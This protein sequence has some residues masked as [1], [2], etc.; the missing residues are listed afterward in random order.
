MFRC[1]SLATPECHP[2]SAGPR[3]AI[4]KARQNGIRQKRGSRA[5]TT[6]ILHRQDTVRQGQAPW[7]LP[8]LNIINILPLTI[9]A[10]LPQQTTNLHLVPCLCLGRCRRLEHVQLIEGSDAVAAAK[11]VHVVLVG[12]RG[13]CPA[14]RRN[15]PVRLRLKPLK[16]LCLRCSYTVG[17]LAMPWQAAM[18]SQSGTT[19]KI[20]NPIPLRT[21]GTTPHPTQPTA[22]IP[23]SRTCKSLK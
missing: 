23:Q 15:F 5:L 13:V 11:D 14:F 6:R 21:P 8:K 19:H 17:A 7:A 1:G 2:L 18:A 20:A 10:P 16:G 12:N 4:I 22:G 9:H 3:G